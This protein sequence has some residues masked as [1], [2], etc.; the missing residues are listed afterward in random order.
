MK[1]RVVVHNKGIHKGILFVVGLGPGAES[2]LSPL[3]RQALEQSQV[4]AGYGRYIDLVSPALKAGKELIVSGMTREV[5]RCKAAMAA[6]CS[7]ESVSL[8]CSGDPG[9]YALAGLVLEIMEVEGITPEELPVEIIPGVPA[10]CAAAARLGAPLT[11][12]F[13]CISFSDLLTP[14]ELIEKRLQAAMAADFVLAV[15]N[16]SS[17]NRAANFARALELM[18]AALP[19]DTPVG[20]VREV[21]RP[22]EK[23]HLVTLGALDPAL[24]DML[25]IVIVGN[26]QS[27]I[28][29]AD[30]SAP[31]LLTPR[32]YARKYEL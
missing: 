21:Y 6:A 31:R 29:F 19:S 20:V 15:H 7:G 18:R 28:I 5:E 22:E 27:R 24:V 1:Q 32:G 2:L 3:A 26:S 23:A 11:H 9:V 16:P 25:S 30:S 14:W 4:I 12:D 10:V 17:R 8:V 13:A